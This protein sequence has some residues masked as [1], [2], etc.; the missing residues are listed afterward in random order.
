LV[1]IAAHKEGISMPVLSARCFGAEL[2]SEIERHAPRT[3]AA[4]EL[5]TLRTPGVR[6]VRAAAE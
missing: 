1:A 5:V 6:H 3:A 4:E 2:N